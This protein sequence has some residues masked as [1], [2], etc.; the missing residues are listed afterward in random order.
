MMQQM[1][2]SALLT[3]DFQGNNYA[4]KMWYIDSSTSNHM[5]LNPTA[6][7]HVWPYTR[8]SF[9]QTAN[10]SSLPNSTV[11]FLA[12]K[13]STNLIFLGQLV[14]RNCA[15]NFFDDGCVVQDQITGTLIAKGPKVGHLFH[16][17]CCSNNISSFSKSIT[18]LQQIFWF[19]YSVTSSFRS[20]QYSNPVSC[21]EL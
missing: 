1:I 10:G 6:L 5:M 13:L 18:C 21:I 11:V 2:V 17:I 15:V 7:G 4:S 3:L 16:Y 14:D 8:T 12:S 9:I 20:F 19:K